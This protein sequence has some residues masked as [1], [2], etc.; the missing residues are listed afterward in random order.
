MLPITTSGW[1]DGGLR[2][3]ATN[4]ESDSCGVFPDQRALRDGDTPERGRFSA[5]L[6]GFGQAG[7]RIRAC[8]ALARARVRDDRSSLMGGGEGGRRKNRA[9]NPMHRGV[10]SLLP[11]DHVLFDSLKNVFRFLYALT[12][13]SGLRLGF[14]RVQTMLP[15]CTPRSF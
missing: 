5:E 13:E 12:E 11:V 14:G 10:S 8:P 4:D 6:G 7:R 2:Y 3:R 9:M 1:A 15:A